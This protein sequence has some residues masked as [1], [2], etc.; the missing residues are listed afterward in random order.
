MIRQF[1]APPSITTDVTSQL[2]SSS[3]PQFV[4]ASEVSSTQEYVSSGDAILDGVLGGGGF[5]RGCITEVFGEAGCGKTQLLMHTAMMAAC[6]GEMVLFCV[7]EPLPHTRL[8][9]LAAM[10]DASHG[11]STGGA[12]LLSHI[13]ITRVPSEDH[14]L[15]VL[16]SGDGPAARQASS[17]HVTL[18]LL[19]SIAAACAG[20]APGAA[21]R[22][23]YRL[24]SF[25]VQYD[26]AV[27]VSNQV[28]ARPGGDSSSKPMA[29]MGL[30]WACTL[31]TRIGLSRP[32]GRSIGSGETIVVEGLDEHQRAVTGRRLCESVFSPT[33][34][35]FRLEYSI[36]NAGVHFYRCC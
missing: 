12:A 2:L 13:L 26:V 3:L 7:S 23:G 25:A 28:R 31:H 10:Y 22:I 35:P 19:D 30:G 24:K 14:V 29:S 11:G 5:R 9:Q 8:S 1:L 20:S 33:Q 18:L 6:R 15:R 32:Y 17:S 27:V 4:P 16:A 21:E 34:P 36:D